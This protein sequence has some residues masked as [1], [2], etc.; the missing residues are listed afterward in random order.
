MTCVKTGFYLFGKGKPPLVYVVGV[1]LSAKPS[2]SRSDA[3][4]R[5]EKITDAVLA[6]LRAAGAR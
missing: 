2:S 4:R 5:L 3:S 1:A 6:V